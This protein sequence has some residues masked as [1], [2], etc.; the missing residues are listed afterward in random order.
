[1]K[2]KIPLY[3]FLIFTYLQNSFGQKN[4]A[5][6][7]DKIKIITLDPGH[8]HAA[9]IQKTMYDNIDSIVHVYSP[10]NGTQLK[11]HLV[12]IDRYN[13]RTDNPTKWKEIQYTGSNYFEKMIKEK[14][15]NVVV[16][17]GNNKLKTNYI[18]KSIDAGLNVLADKPMVISFDGFKTLEKTF[19]NAEKK[20][21]VLYDIM[22]E[23]FEINNVLQRYF[24]QCFEVFGNLQKGDLEN[25][26]V[27][28]ESVHHFFK[29]V[30]DLPLIRPSWYYDINQEGNGI[31]D[32][33][34]HLVDLIQWQC[35]S[36]QV[37]DYKTDIK[38]LTANRWATSI[39][40]GQF[41]LS[42][43]QEPFPDFLKYA[44]V[45]DT[46]RVF[47]NGDMN[48]TIKNVHAKVSVKWNFQAPEG[49]G[50][51]HFSI[52]RGTKS[53]II[54]R[55][56]AEQNYKPVLYIEPLKKT[57]LI[58]KYLIECIVS[59]QKNYPG[60]SLIPTNKGWKV[61][62]PE[63]FVLGHEACFAEVVKNYLQ[64]LKEKRLP[65]WEVKNML[66]KYYTTTAALEK[67]I[68]HE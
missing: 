21:L 24:M 68:Q 17:A 47:A 6:Q 11:A 13:S 29:Y 53:N 32:V 30:S 57:E 37:I 56:S 15:G 54:I 63:K 12:L 33:T 7:N 51:T 19:L 26:A 48:Y 65:I 41:K 35:F 9:L 40:A 62:I 42:T 36:D 67:A 28:V 14:A 39:S 25:P 45:K 22:T 1:M 34:T 31:V 27:E 2:F 64:Y 66:A 43:Q 8:F 60:V 38:M 44:I 52:V 23:R 4:I 16:I 10:E 18:S 46:L 59:L 58:E 5:N 49:T 3:F 61:S 20:K 55:Q 50:D